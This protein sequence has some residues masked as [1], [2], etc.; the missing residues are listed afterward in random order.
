MPQNRWSQGPPSRHLQMPTYFWL[1]GGESSFWVCK[2][3]KQRLRPLGF[4]TAN[5]LR[6]GTLWVKIRC[7]LTRLSL[8]D[9]TFNE[10]RADCYIM[11]NAPQRLARKM[12]RPTQLRCAFPQSAATAFSSTALGDR[13]DKG[14]QLRFGHVSNYGNL[15]GK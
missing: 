5:Y 14:R 10:S 15:E 4:S 11:G 6:K 13:T 12:L 8:V 2:T 1:L 3:P 7:R 9:F